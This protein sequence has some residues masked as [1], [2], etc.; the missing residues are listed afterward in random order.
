MK[1]V[2]QHK[3][4]MKKTLFVV[5]WVYSLVLFCITSFNPSYASEGI[6][7]DSVIESIVWVEEEQE[8][9]PAVN[10]VVV[11]QDEDDEQEWDVKDDDNDLFWAEISGDTEEGKQDSQPDEWT[12]LDA[13][14]DEW[15]AEDDDIV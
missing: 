13:Q 4:K 10:N 5:F 9:E 12:L 8:I 14:D 7:L 6:V 2:I 1:K 15:D 11:Y 3:S